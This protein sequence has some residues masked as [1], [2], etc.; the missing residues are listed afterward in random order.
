MPGTPPTPLIQGIGASSLATRSRRPRGFSA[1]KNLAASVSFITTTGGAFSSSPG[2]LG[3][4]PGARPEVVGDL[5]PAGGVA[6]GA[7]RQ[8]HAGEEHAFGAEA[9][10]DVDQAGE[11]AEH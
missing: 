2:S 7:R 3:R 11:A 6:V 10:V 1:P 9:G 5:H 8:R 4:P